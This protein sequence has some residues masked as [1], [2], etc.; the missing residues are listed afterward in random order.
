MPS[1]I[2]PAILSALQ[3]AEP[4]AD[5][6]FQ[7]SSSQFQSSS[8]NKTYFAKEG[9]PSD[10]E[11]YYGEAE[12]LRAM[13]AASPGICPRL[14]ECSVDAS[15]KRPVFVSEHKKIGALNKHSA[16][17]L[18]SGLAEM[19]MKGKSPT[20]KFGFEVPT[21]CGATRM[22]NGW[23]ETWAEA[24]DRMIG[25]LLER[26]K[27]NNQYE[28]T[29]QLGEEVRKRVIPVLLGSLQIQPAL[30]HGDLWSGNAGTDN[31][32]GRPI[33]FDPSSYYGHNEAD[34]SIARIFGG[35]PPSFFTTYHEHIPRS[36][37]TA[38]YDQRS[39]LYELFHYLNHTALFGRSYESS[40]RQKMTQL[41][42]YVTDNKQMSIL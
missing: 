32:S 29:C 4:D 31:E 27:Q 39:A 19:H 33:I 5:K 42:R 10:A 3:R 40:A 35:F 34:L 8:S 18:G 2:P 30:V 25:G 12:S 6:F 20:G 28:E 13:Y 15:S 36:E 38:E 9:S 17:A 37:P 7:S 1:S 24:Y 14:F 21:Y 22:E 41:L 26:L 23:S 16:K 11:Q